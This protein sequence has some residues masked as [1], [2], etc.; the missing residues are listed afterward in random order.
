MDRAPDLV[1]VRELTRV[2]GGTCRLPPEI[3]RL[4]DQ[5]E[6]E[7]LITESEHV[8]SAYPSSL[9]ER[10][11]EDAEAVL[12]ALADGSEWPE[13]KAW[14]GIEWNGKEFRRGGVST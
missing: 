6:L 3:Q 11:L 13:A 8:P 7:Y 2:R 1:C 4:I 14:D 5:L 9:R 12:R 10:L